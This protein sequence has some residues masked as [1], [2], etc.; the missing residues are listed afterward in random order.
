MRIRGVAT[1]V[2]ELEEGVTSAAAPVRRDGTLAGVI[3]VDGPTSRIAQ[4]RVLP[5]IVDRL[6]ETA[7]RV[8]ATL[9]RSTEP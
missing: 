4:A 2:D 6:A 9:A 3:V 5:R 8:E 1:A 7:R